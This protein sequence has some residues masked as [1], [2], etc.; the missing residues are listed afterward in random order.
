MLKNRT[1]TILA[2]SLAARLKQYGFTK[3]GSA[4][5]RTSGRILHVVD[6]Q[7]SR[8]SD[9]K[10]L[11]FTLNCGVYVPGVTS[12]FRN[13]REPHRPKPTDCCIT[14]RVGMLTE[15][16][17]DVWWKVSEDD[18]P[19]ADVETTKEIILIIERTILPFFDRFLEEKVVADFLSQHRTK[20]DEHIE[21]RAEELRLV[22]AAIILNMLGDGDGCRNF[23]AQALEKARKGPLEEVIGVFVKR[24]A[25]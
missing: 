18:T 25:C 13:M 12:R 17:L 24:F 15:S 11:S 5:I 3:Q 10:E 14:A 21:P 22:Y 19:D 4:W 9:A 6:V 1:K 7:H 2:N 8:W 23:I 16:K 20:A